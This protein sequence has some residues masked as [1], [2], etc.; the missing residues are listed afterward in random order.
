M[1]SRNIKPGLFKNEKLAECSFAAR[2]FFIGLWCYADKKGL[3][4]YRPKRMKIEI[5]P[6]DRS[7]PE[8]L[9]KELIDT[10][11]IQSYQVNDSKYLKIIN[12]T[13]HQRPHSTEK[14][15]TFPD[16]NKQN[17]LNN[18]DNT[19]DNA[20]IPDSLIPERGKRKEEL[21]NDLVFVSFYALYPKRAEKAEALKQWLKLSETELTPEFIIEVLIAQKEAG[22]FPDDPKYIMSPRKWLF[23]KRWEDEIVKAQNNKPAYVNE[24]VNVIKGEVSYDK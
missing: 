19:L 21:F 23:G 24:H 1:R 5:L 22:M 11:F 17:T 10:G 18:G 15:S 12:F 3:C 20:L 2:L 13:K 9:I 16:I 4:E 7:K 14:E 8:E 6:Y